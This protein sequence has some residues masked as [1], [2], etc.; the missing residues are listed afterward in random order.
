MIIWPYYPLGL[1][2]SFF[3][4]S[5]SE[6]WDMWVNSQKSTCRLSVSPLQ[7]SKSRNF[8]KISRRC[9]NL[10]QE[11]IWDMWV[12]SQKST[13]VSP[14]MFL[15]YVKKQK[16]SPKIQE[17]HTPD[18]EIWDM[19]GNFTKIDMLKFLIAPEKCKKAESFAKIYLRAQTWCKN[20]MLKFETR[21][22]SPQ[23]STCEMFTKSLKDVKKQQ[24]CVKIT[25]VHKPDAKSETR[26]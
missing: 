17:M 8:C 16:V 21:E 11:I 7:M 25:C 6:I 26:E 18:A 12:N 19:W 13:Y 10:M 22:E 2:R 20:V 14:L 15:N 4:V 24:K 3:L 9:T 5:G 1:V 23:K